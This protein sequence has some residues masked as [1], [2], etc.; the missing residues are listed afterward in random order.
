MYVGTSTFCE[1]TKYSVLELH[2]FTNIR[3]LLRENK[4]PILTTLM[5]TSVPQSTGHNSCMYVH[6][7]A[8]KCLECSS[9]VLLT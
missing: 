5:R 6:I 4:F 3:S 8:Y 1:Q 2:V 7:H 9:I